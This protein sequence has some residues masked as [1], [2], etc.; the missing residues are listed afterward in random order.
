MKL[1][2]APGYAILY[3]S[4]LFPNEWG[5]K[6]SVAQ[7]GRQWKHRHVLAPI[8]SI[9]FYFFLLFLIIGLIQSHFS[10]V[11]Q[12]TTNT[13]VSSVNTSPDTDQNAIQN[14]SSIKTDSTSSNEL[15]PAVSNEPKQNEDDFEVSFATFIDNLEKEKNYFG[16]D[17]I[18]R[19]RLKLPQKKLT[20]SSQIAIWKS[21]SSLQNKE[22]AIVLILIEQCK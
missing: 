3:I 1:I 19:C 7:S 22:E 5:K 8:F 2:W 13:N 15:Q 16:N 10:G 20:T 21:N 12:S 17:Q 11:S 18:I 6:R 4:Y 9:I 14:N